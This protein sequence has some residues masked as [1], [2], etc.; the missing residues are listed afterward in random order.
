MS[1]LKWQELAKNKSKIGDKINYT[2][3]FITK[4]KIGQQTDQETFGKLLKP[5][6]NKLDDV[7]DNNLN[8]FI[9]RRKQLVKKVEVPDYGIHVEDDV[10]DMNLGDIFNEQQ[11]LPES[12][13]QI[14]LKPPTYD[15]SMKDIFD[16][17]EIYVDPQYF[18]QDQDLPPEY[19]E[20]EGID[21]AMTD[22]D[23]TQSLL[24][25]L[26]LP[27][28]ES[29][30][31]VLNQPEMTP[32]KSRSYLNKIIKDA[33]LKKNQL[34]GKKAT[35][36]KY[37][38]S[39]KISNAERQEYNKLIEK[40]NNVLREYINHYDSKVDTMKGSGIRV[41]GKK[42][43]GGNVVFFNDPKKLLNKLELII[44]SLNAGNTSIQMRNTG[45]NIL[46]ILLRMTTINRSQYNKLYNQYFKV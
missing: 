18:P 36:T 12:E 11:V 7:I 6:T 43:R 2:R 41:R 37:Y 29:I 40:Q 35:V 21:Y 32:K 42:H 8:M 16:G 25:D 22:Y 26:E 15:E 1:L 5:V 10:E 27:N 3:D 4:H 45:V 33:K 20:Y 39:G 34:K 17:K 28:Y 9:P 19:D 46:N 30:G 13:K 38:N 44:G 31:M 24:D 23:E 14:A